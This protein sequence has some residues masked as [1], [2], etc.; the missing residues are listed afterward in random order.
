MFLAEINC[1]PA[2]LDG[3]PPLAH[4]DELPVELNT[5]YLLLSSLPVGTWS[6]RSCEF[7]L[8]SYY[9]S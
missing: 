3:F 4:K 8:A 9:C 5:K 6:C 1:I 7:S 2:V